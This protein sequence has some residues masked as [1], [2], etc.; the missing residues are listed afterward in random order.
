MKKS[1]LIAPG[2]FFLCL[3]AGAARYPL[4]GGAGLVHVQ[5]AKVGPG[6]GFRSLNAFSHYAASALD[7]HSIYYNSSYLDLWSYNTIT[8]SPVKDLGLFVTGLGHGEKWSFSRSDVNLD[9]TLGC[10]G[11]PALSAKYCF[12]L[13]GGKFDLGLMPMV[14]IPLGKEGT[15]PDGTPI[16][17][18][19]HSQSGRL[20]FG[21][22][23][24]GDINLGRTILYAN[25]GFIT[26]G[27]QR[28]QVPLGLAGEYGISSKFSAF[29]EASGELRVGSRQDSSTA[30]W[31]AES[32][33]GADDNEFRVTPGV[34]FVPFDLLAINL[35]A[36]IG[37][38]KAT[39]SWQIVLGFDFPAAAGRAAQTMILGGIAGL[40]KDRDSYVPMK[41]M[42][43]FPGSDL[44]GLVSDDMGNY[45]A[46]LPPGEYKIHIYANGY[47]WLERKIQV[48]P[49]KT[50]KWDLTLKR[51]LGTVAGKVVDAVRGTPIAATL[52]FAGSSLP[53]FTSDSG[54]GEFSTQVPPG[55][56]RLTA[57][58]AGYQGQE[59]EFAVKDKAEINQVIALKPLAVASAPA[60]TSVPPYP[61]AP[62][63]SSQPP[64]Q[65]SQPKPAATPPARTE[66]PKP[67][68]PAAPAATP[69]PGK[70]TPEEIESL[71]KAG[72]KQFMNEDFKTAEAT[73]LK[74]LKADPK[75]AKAKD[76]L[77]KTRARLKLIK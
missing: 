55:K 69:A 49:G 14:T 74:V 67:P 73:F 45:L 13:A 3:A 36:D 30:A 77:N 20:D 23:A 26:R 19:P 38:T 70:L 11:D 32:S 59:F 52:S 17:T 40:I 57:Q 51:K 62:P 12:H 18:D 50:I 44:P 75:H 54:S 60:A 33:M 24:L 2:L 58:A 46:N 10:P 1:A 25:L 4:F 39:P 37:L 21:A 61:P 34:R 65:P 7:T 48:E 9:P 27:E 8:Y 76:Y 15:N 72:V 29:L 66:P 5:S 35:S 22:K 43:T 16:L 64:A 41:G 71:Y 31:F 6:F 42:I 53:A 56:Y 68:A 28:P 63:R 47:R